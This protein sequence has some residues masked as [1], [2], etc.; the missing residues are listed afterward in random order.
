M[1]EL[2][3]CLS[4]PSSTFNH[5]SANSHLKWGKCLRVLLWEWNQICYWVIYYAESIWLP[6]PFKYYLFLPVFLIANYDF[7]YHICL[8][9]YQCSLNL[10]VTSWSNSMHHFL[11][12]LFYIFVS[13]LNYFLELDFT[14]FFFNLQSKKWK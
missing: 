2:C 10:K 4:R 12:C 3:A 9:E 7:R 5:H 11:H 13:E 1:D 8:D 6:A 14:F